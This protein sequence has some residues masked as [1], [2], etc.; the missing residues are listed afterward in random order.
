M[1]LE[2]V[3]KPEGYELRERRAEKKGSGMEWKP[4]DA[5]YSASQHMHGEYPPTVA[6]AVVWYTRTTEGKLTLKW[7]IAYETER[8]HVALAADFLKEMTD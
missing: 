7:D 1:T 3:P 6:C 5:L 8:A 2:I 4:L